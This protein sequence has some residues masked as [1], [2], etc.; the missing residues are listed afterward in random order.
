LYSPI[1]STLLSLYFPHFSCT[2]QQF[3]WL[4]PTVCPVTP[5]VAFQQSCHY[6]KYEMVY[7][8]EF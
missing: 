7:A 2:L 3:S 4:P 1:L 6:W 5:P 8:P